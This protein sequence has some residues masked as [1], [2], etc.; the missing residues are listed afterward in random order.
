MPA[1]EVKYLVKMAFTMSSAIMAFT[2]S[3]AD[4]RYCGKYPREAIK[5][6]DKEHFFGLDKQP[7]FVGNTE[8]RCKRPSEDIHWVAM[9]VSALYLLYEGQSNFESFLTTES[10]RSTIEGH[11]KF[12]LCNGDNLTCIW[13][14]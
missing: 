2:I 8:P 14:A 10:K 12:V 4:E 11:V 6:G 7:A 9:P 5:G 3:S 13:L 1:H